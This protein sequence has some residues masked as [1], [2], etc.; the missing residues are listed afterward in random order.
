M[1]CIFYQTKVWWELWGDYQG[2]CQGGRNPKKA[3]SW[4]SVTGGYPTPFFSA[5]MNV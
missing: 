5:I 3:D 1:G 4:I 2:N